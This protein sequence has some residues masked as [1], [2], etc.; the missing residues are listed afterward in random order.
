MTFTGRGTTLHYAGN[1]AL[2]IYVHNFV[3][4][5]GLYSAYWEFLD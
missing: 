5:V 1:K 4:G 3:N 2:P